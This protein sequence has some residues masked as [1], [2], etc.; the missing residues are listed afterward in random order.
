[1]ISLQWKEGEKIK[2]AKIS[3]KEA[4]EELLGKTRNPIDTILAGTEKIS[5]VTRGNLF[6]NKLG[7]DFRRNKILMQREKLVISK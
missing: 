4:I 3:K 5:Q 2:E 7:N 6:L 1:M